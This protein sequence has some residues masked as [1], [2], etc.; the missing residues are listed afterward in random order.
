LIHYYLKNHV[1][2]GDTT[3]KLHT[4]AI[5]WTHRVNQVLITSNSCTTISN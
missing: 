3:H 5:Y 4:T 1:T 2:D